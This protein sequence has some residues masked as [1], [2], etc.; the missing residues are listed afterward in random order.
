M[1]CA[2]NLGYY[3]NKTEELEISEELHVYLGK[4][5]KKIVD[6]MESGKMIHL[7]FN[8]EDVIFPPNYNGHADSGY[9]L[10]L[11]NLSLENNV[12]LKKFIEI[13]EN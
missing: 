3:N 8:P 9:D 7:K 6:M 5:N 10:A 1:T 13:H 12:K 2:H 11:L 4:W